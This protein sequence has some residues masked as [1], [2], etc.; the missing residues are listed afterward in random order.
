MNT[1]PG[2]Y[3]L[4]LKSTSESTVEIGRLGTLELRKGYYVYVGSAF[5]LG[6]LRART[7]RHLQTSKK[8][9]WHIDYLRPVTEIYEIWYSN[10]PLRWEHNWAKVFL[11]SCGYPVPLRGFGSSDCDCESHLFYA[12][13]SPRL[14]AFC[15]QLREAS[16][17]H[18]EVKR[19]IGGPLPGY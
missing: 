19:W 18:C 2:T 3:A 13:N 5:G 4:I 16:P 14:K 10:D 8:C 15:S 12:V 7:R 9:Y 1:E 6:G 17:S 11:E